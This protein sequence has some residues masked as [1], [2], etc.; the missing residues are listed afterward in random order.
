MAWKS[1]EATKEQGER[2]KYGHLSLPPRMQPEKSA[3][4]CTTEEAYQ[5]LKFFSPAS[6]ETQMLLKTS[7][8]LNLFVV[9]SVSSEVGHLHFCPVNTDCGQRGL[10][11]KT[12]PKR[13][14]CADL[15]QE[16]LGTG[17]SNSYR[18]HLAQ[19]PGRQF[20]GKA[21]G[22]TH[23]MDSLS[24]GES[25]ISSCHQR[26]FCSIMEQAKRT[27]GKIITTF[28]QKSPQRVSL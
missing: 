15:F 9:L 19:A 11:L 27:R 18:S 22:H 8:K 4:Q 17:R 25:S 20:Q 12:G 13:D 23:C 5:H 26:L 24:A 7:Q 10:S 2:A 28:L 14:V 6:S 1:L 16:L 21:T 3:G